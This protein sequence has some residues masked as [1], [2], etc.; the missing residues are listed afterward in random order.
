MSTEHGKL[1]GNRLKVYKEI[2]ENLH[3][4]FRFF[5]D[6]FNNA[7]QW[8]ERKKRYTE[9]IATM[10]IIG[11]V[12]GLGDRHA[13]NIL[14]DQLTG[15][16]VHI[17]FGIAFDQGKLLTTPEL[18]PF[19]LTRDIVDGFGIEGVYGSFKTTA[20]H[21]LRI[22]K[23]KYAIIMTI[24]NVLRYD[25]LY[26]WEMA[27]KRMKDSVRNNDAERALLG[28]QKKLTMS[29]SV[30]CQVNELIQEATDESNLS[31][32]FPGWYVY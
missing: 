9:S 1:N 19:R 18:V 25:P 29:V 14:L 16:V 17:D 21:I 32:M 22:L 2:T 28:V 20:C 23:D 11:Y 13:Q 10:S 6:E 30:E 26:Q 12:V 31:R 15:E 5:F 4:A 27:A 24:L 8:L 7:M 3:P